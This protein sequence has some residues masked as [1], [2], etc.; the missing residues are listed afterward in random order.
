MQRKEWKWSWHLLAS[1][2]ASAQSSAPSDF[3]KSAWFRPTLEENLHEVC[4]EVLRGVREQFFSANPMRQLTEPHGSMD[5]GSL[6]RMSESSLETET[7]EDPSATVEDQAARSVTNQL[8]TV[9]ERRVYL[10][11]GATPG[12][13]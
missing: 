9:D 12:C 7:F 2:A 3:E 5:I 4:S 1:A 10:R 13:G 6:R 8:V 11:F